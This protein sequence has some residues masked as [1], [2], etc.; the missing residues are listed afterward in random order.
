MVSA[1]RWVLGL[2]FGFVG[3]LIGGYIFGVSAEATV[4]YLIENI[5]YLSVPGLRVLIRQEVEPFVALMLI[6]GVIPGIIFGLPT[7]GGNRGIRALIGAGLGFL[8][9]LF[10]YYILFGMPMIQEAA[11]ESGLGFLEFLIVLTSAE[12]SPLNWVVFATFII[13][14]VESAI[15]GSVFGRKEAR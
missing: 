7:R 2:M 13:G 10:G 14:M 15:L 6:S 9:I 11:T 5:K 4:S 12:V 1:G 3:A 8:C